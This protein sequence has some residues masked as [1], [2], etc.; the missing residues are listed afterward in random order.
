[1]NK[2]EFFLMLSTN[3]KLKMRSNNMIRLLFIFSG[4]CMPEPM[5]RLGGRMSLAVQVLLLGL[6]AQLTFVSSLRAEDAASAPS[7]TDFVASESYVILVGDKLSY[8]VLEDHDEPKLLVVS[9]TGEIEIPYF[10]QVVVAGKT[11]SDAKKEIKGLLEKKLYQQA[12]VLLAIAE[13]ARKSVGPKI[14][15]VVVVGQ[16]K[17][18]GAQDMPF[19]EKYMLSR[20]ILKAGGLAS[21]ANGKKVQVIRK[22]ADGKGEKIVVDVLSILKEGKLENDI[23]LQADDMIIVPE[24]LINF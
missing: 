22:T 11:L 8:R 9:P 13:T 12:T 2:I 20:A 15:Q 17:T 4:F 24:K 19:G 14:D 7:G 6:S 21:F 23:E 10:G 16:V 1:M 3:F 5:R 18:L